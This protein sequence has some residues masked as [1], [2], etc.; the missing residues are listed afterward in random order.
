MVNV[1]AAAVP[2][3]RVSQRV[4]ELRPSRAGDDAW[5][6]KDTTR[7]KSFEVVDFSK[8]DAASPLFVEWHV[9]PE[10]NEKRRV[11]LV[12]ARGAVSR[13][14]ALGEHE[15]EP[16][17]TGLTYCRATGYVP[18]ATSHWTIP[19]YPSTVTSFSI[20]TMDTADEMFVLLG[21]DV[22]HVLVRATPDEK[23]T[24]AYDV[25]ISGEPVVKETVTDGEK[26]FDCDPPAG[27]LLPPP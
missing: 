1:D 22:L 12:L 20:E 19:A 7:A 24:L 3:P 27:G 9:A 10:E 4:P 21:K 11:D 16:A 14:L 18:E 13:R 25:R 15:G 2:S 17:A 6:A 23:W 8:A 26:P 5:I